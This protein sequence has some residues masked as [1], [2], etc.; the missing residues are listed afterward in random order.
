ML[1]GTQLRELALRHSHI[2]AG[3]E[4]AEKFDFDAIAAELNSIDAQA[5]TI[6]ELT[7]KLDAVRDFADEMD[8][9]SD[10]HIQNP[11]TTKQAAVEGVCA[12]RLLSILDAPTKE[13]K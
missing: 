2:I 10:K 9:H 1:T 7:A 6:A 12:N 5:Q 3:M 13:P 11:I 4:Y 8:R